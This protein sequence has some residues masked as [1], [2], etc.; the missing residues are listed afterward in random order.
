MAASSSDEKRINKCKFKNLI[1]NHQVNF[2]ATCRNNKH[3]VFS[4]KGHN[5]NKK[6][7]KITVQSTRSSKIMRSYICHTQSYS[8]WHCVIGPSADCITRVTLA[9]IVIVPRSFIHSHENVLWPVYRNNWCYLTW[10]CRVELE[11]HDWSMLGRA[12]SQ[13]LA[14][15]R[16]V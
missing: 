10:L 7:L 16:Q 4:Q 14:L 9:S 6:C 5:M 2:R 13:Q 15:Y 8:Q 12:S 11:Y 3:T 1:S